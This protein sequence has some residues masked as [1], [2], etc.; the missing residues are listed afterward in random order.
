MSS[1]DLTLEIRSVGGRIRAPRVYSILGPEW[2]LA[3]ESASESSVVELYP[4]VDGEYE[5]RAIALSGGGVAPHLRLY[6]DAEE[7]HRRVAVINKPGWEIGMEIAG[8][9]HSG[10]AQTSALSTGDSDPL[11]VPTSRHALLHGAKW[12]APGSAPLASG[13]KARWATEAS[14]GSTPSRASC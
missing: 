12:A 13:I 14:F 4:D 5:I 7:S 2:A 11:Q 1:S 3:P 8:G 6:R 9:W 10:F